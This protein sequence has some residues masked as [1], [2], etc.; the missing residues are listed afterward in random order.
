M[1]LFQMHGLGKLFLALGPVT[2]VA[3]RDRSWELATAGQR[4]PR[5]LDQ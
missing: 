2:Q 3:D 4:H 5:K 1:K